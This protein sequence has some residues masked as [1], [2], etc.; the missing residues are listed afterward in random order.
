MI[1]PK[2]WS[3]AR[4]LDEAKQE[5][6]A[7]NPR[8]HQQETHRCQWGNVIQI[9]TLKD[10]EI[11]DNWTAHDFIEIMI[12]SSSVEIPFKDDITYLKQ[13]TETKT[14]V[15]HKARLFKP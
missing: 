7:V 4:G 1:V 10:T 9:T 5:A 12:F 6:T 8:V 2:S 13:G 14:K 15:N 3:K 11:G